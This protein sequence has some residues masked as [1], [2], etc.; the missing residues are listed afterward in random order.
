MLLLT[1]SL[2]H[3]IYVDV[4]NMGTHMT[5]HH[6]N[7]K[8]ALLDRAAEVIADQG[9]EAL[10]LRGLARDVGVSH[11]APA[12]HFRDKKALLSALATEG[13][14]RFSAYVTDAAE[15][16]GSDPVTRYNAMGRSVIRFA[17]TY[18]AYYATFNHPDVTHEADEELLK[19]HREYMEIVFIAAAEAQAAGWHPNIDPLVLMAFSSAA[20]T[21]AA[22]MV[23]N[24]RGSDIFEGRDL[25][26]L[27]EQIINLVVPP[28]AD[29]CAPGNE[30]NDG[31]VRRG[32]NTWQS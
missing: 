20:A 28:S 26:D 11:A 14:L 4:D 12:R 8:Q 25:E 7:L 19:S 21:G 3:S 9:I 24:R 18:P 1:T 10:S 17:L 31:K 23:T 2:R 22:N 30:D 13:Y 5:Y 6:G 32:E 16:A 15:K 29:L 27:A